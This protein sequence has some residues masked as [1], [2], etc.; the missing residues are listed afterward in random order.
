MVQND[1]KLILA[2]EGYD[3]IG[4]AME[5]H[6][7][8]GGGMVEPIYQQSL[9]LELAMRHI[10][11]QAQ[12]EVDVLYKGI[13]LKSS[14]RPDF[15]LHSKIVVEIKALRAIGD[16]EKAQL[17]NYLRVLRRPVGYVL[18]F[19]PIS[20]LEWRRLVCSEYL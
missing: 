16:T 3:L 20:G 13:V 1:G 6:T 17:I 8:L 18:N 9:E 19:G 7:V 12:E 14:Y 10:P 2:Q 5:V 15:I 11:F 4:A